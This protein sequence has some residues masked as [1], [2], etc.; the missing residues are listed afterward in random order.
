M[1][2]DKKNFQLFST[3]AL[4]LH[5]KTLNERLLIFPSL[6]CSGRQK[7]GP[8]VPVLELQ[9]PWLRLYIF[10]ICKRTITILQEVHHSGISHKDTSPVKRF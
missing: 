8:T 4:A 3:S 7:S 9:L 5:G 6:L 2:R 1:P 10:E